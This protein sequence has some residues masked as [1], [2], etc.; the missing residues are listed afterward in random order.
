MLASTSIFYAC[1]G[2]PKPPK[3]VCQHVAK[4]V[5]QEDDEDSMVECVETMNEVKSKMGPDKYKEF[6]NCVMHAKNPQEIARCG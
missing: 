5:E 1:G 4:V 6:S 3:A 2:S